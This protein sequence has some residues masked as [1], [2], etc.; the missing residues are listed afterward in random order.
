[1]EKR[2]WVIFLAL[3]MIVLLVGCDEQETVN[4]TVCETV[5]NGIAL[6]VDTVK[7]TISDG[8][9]T[10]RYRLSGDKS[11]YDLTITYPNGG[12]YWWGGSQSGGSGG[13]SDAYQEGVLVQKLYVRGGVLVDAVTAAERMNE[14]DTKQGH[15]GKV[16]AGLLLIAL[17]AF[18][19]FAP[20]TSWYLG[21]GWRYKDAQ[22]SDAALNFTRI[23][24]GV[25]ILT[26]IV[27]M[28]FF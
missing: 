2:L 1:M 4:E 28:L 16:F 15:F 3:L 5:I 12:T 7:K 23:S 17:G 11:A 13:W 25:A 24:G 6:R 8:E 18:H 14:A 9:Y 20:E 19:L 21:H 27:V 26:G 22:P 10:Y